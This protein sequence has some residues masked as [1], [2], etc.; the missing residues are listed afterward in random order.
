[1]QIGFATAPEWAGL[2]DDDR[3]AVAALESRGA[4]VVPVVW[5]EPPAADIDILVVRSTWGYQLRVLQFA[6]WL[7]RLDELG[8]PVWNP[9]ALLGWNL[10]KIYLQDL[11]AR[12]VVVTPTEW[13]GGKAPH[14]PGLLEDKGWDAAVVK[15]VVSASGYRTFRTTRA[16][17]H[18]DRDKYHEALSTGAVMVQPFLEEIATEG[19]WSLIF[20]GGIFS[21]A[22]LKRPA[23]GGF[24]VQPEHGGT[25]T[26]AD[27]PPR[28]IDDAAL[29]LGS[30][31][32]RTLYARVDGVRRGDRLVL[33]ELELLEPDLFFRFAPGSADRFAD[34][35]LDLSWRAA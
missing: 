21:H 34:A 10:N 18:A 25:S 33:L 19:E 31:P 2:T 32:G 17:A 30:A 16:T 12:G 28:L 20:I 6:G 24:L 14:L 23:A 27:P 5:T 29:A 11:E 22:V 9:P 8:I 3:L 7:A 1:M 35:L 13:V 4:S 26:P 15:P